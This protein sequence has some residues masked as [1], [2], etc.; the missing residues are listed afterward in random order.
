ML[1]KVRDLIK[2]IGDE[3][4]KGNDDEFNSNSKKTVT[5]RL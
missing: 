1:A 4:S 2:K 5:K 3:T